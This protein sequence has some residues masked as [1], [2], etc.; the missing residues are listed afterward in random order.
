M[1]KNIILI[2]VFAVMT[3]ASSAM[4]EVP[5]INFDGRT[6]G[7]LNFSEAIKTAKEKGGECHAVCDSNGKCATVC[8][9]SNKNAE[10]ELAAIPAPTPVKVDSFDTKG[11]EDEL[12]RSI[13]TAINDCEKKEFATMKSKFEKLLSKGL[14]QEKRDFVY[15]TKQTYEFPRRLFAGTEEAKVDTVTA[16]LNTTRN[17][18]AWDIVQ[19]CTTGQKEVCH[20]VCAAAVLVCVAA[21]N[22]LGTPICSYLAPVCSIA[23]SFV[24]ETSCISVKHCTQHATWP[25]QQHETDPI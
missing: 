23:C 8:T 10:I 17:C 13:G 7:A 1:K 16:L 19:E 21:T 12:N 20:N 6:I 5:Q 4:A 9:Y 18:V 3:A 2:A 15:N 24:P 22:G 14:L 25:G 11:E